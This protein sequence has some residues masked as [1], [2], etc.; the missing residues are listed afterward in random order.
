VITITSTTELEVATD[1]YSDLSVD[2]SSFYRVG[3]VVDYLPEGDHD[4]AITGLEIASIVGNV[5]TFTSAHGV[6]ATGGTLEPTTYT[7]ASSTQ[8]ADAYLASNTSPPVLGSTT[9][10]QRYS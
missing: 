10:A 4:N 6:S 9:E 1:I 8:Q 2:D 3:D 5:L 7:S